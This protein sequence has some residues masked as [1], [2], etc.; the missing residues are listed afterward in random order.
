MV[1]SVLWD[2]YYVLFGDVNRCYHSNSL[3]RRRPE[4]VQFLGTLSLMYARGDS[5][6]L[7]SSSEV[8]KRQ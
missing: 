5:L 4:A 1:G 3:S 7:R 8:A 2:V 6:L